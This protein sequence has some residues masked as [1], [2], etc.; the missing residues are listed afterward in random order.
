M[1]RLYSLLVIVTYYLILLGCNNND[2]SPPPPDVSGQ[3]VQLDWIR[4]DQELQKLDSE[5]PLVTYN[6]LLASYPQITDLYFKRLMQVYHRNP[7]SLAR[8]LSIFSK[9]ERIAKLGKQINDKFSNTEEIEKDLTQALKYYQHYFPNNTL[10]RFY[11]IFTEYGYP[12]LIFN[13]KDGRDGIGIGLDLFLGSNYDYKSVN[14]TDPV[15]SDYITRTYNEEHLIKK[16]MEM[17]IQ[18]AIGP[19]PGKRFIDRMINQGKKIYLLKKV[20]PTTPDSI[21]FE[22]TSEQMAWMKASELQVW[23]FYLSEELM[24][25]TNHLK[26]SKFLN[27]APST[28]GMPDA[29]PGRTTDYLGYKIVSAFMKRQPDNTMA[30]LIAMKDAQLL[31]EQSKYKPKRK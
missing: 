4:F 29:A 10:P 13:D 26:L 18:D 24:Y 14:P 31:L 11:T 20:L 21:I 1:N 5:K 28:Q 25:E 6:Q 7:D 23:D 2:S 8:R 15:F 22:Y 17:V 12:T 3:E 30:D 19:A 27:P 9:D 16:T